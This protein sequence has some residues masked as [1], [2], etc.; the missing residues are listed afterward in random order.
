MPPQ[1]SVAWLLGG[2]VWG[3]FIFSWAMAAGPLELHL[4]RGCSARAGAGSFPAPRQN[5]IAP[6]GP[7]PLAWGGPWWGLTA[8]SWG[9]GCDGQSGVP[10]T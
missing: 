10:W 8:G 7:E 6:A 4:H 9:A 1:W 2:L 5:L 3:S